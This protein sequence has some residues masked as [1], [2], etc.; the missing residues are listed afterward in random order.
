MDTTKK[1]SGLASVYAAG[2]PTYSD[3]F[4][5]DLYKK[6][7]FSPESVVADIGSGTGIFAKK[8]IEKG[9]FT[10]CIEPNDDMLR[11]AMK[12]LMDYKNCKCIAGDAANTTLKSNSVDFITAAQAFHWFDAALFHKECKRILKQNGRAFLIWNIRDMDSVITQKNYKINEKYC[13]DFKGFHGGINRDDDRIKMFFNGEY[14][15]VEYDNPLY[16]NKEKFLKRCRSASY[17]LKPKEGKYGEYIGEL[18]ELFEEYADEGILI[19]PNK[20]VAYIGTV[21]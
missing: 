10:Y 5:E 8:M 11:Q 2:R 4:I 7:G 6:Y 20:T 18:E 17:S 19:L 21:N 3:I 13:P 14:E 12:E 1:F 16:Y 9:T 15:R